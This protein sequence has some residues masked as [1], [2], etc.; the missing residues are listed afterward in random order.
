MLRKIQHLEASLD[1]S[2]DMLSPRT[3]VK[4]LLM[5]YKLTLMGQF[6]DSYSERD[7]YKM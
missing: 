7:T 4:V 3:K 2:I 5:F 1:I 6:I